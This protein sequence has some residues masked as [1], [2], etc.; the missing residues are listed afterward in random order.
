[1]PKDYYQILEVPKEADKDQLK[2]AYRNLAQQWHPDKHQQDS[3]EQEEAAEKFKEISEA[4][5]VLSD[6]EKKSNYDLTG[7]PNRGDTHGFRMHGDPFDIFRAAGFGFRNTRAAGPQPIKGQAV[8]EVIE[9]PLKAA[10]F[11]S[12]WSLS[13]SVISAC[14]RC[15]GKRGIEF[16]VCGSCNGS[17]FSVH[18]QPNMIM[19]TP[20]QD[21]RGQGQSIKTLCDTCNGQGTETENKILNVKIPKGIPHGTTLRLGG[22]GG[23]G[24]NGGPPGDVF[25]GVKVNYPDLD[26]LSDEEKATLGRLLSN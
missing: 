12:E 2:K 26:L 19:H 9:I 1:M 22:Q 3:K 16:E 14:S 7:D 5:S 18:K 8:H 6:P 20:C 21:C 25:L 10:L 17:G 11:G 13:F 23:R 15:S 4:Y 24:L